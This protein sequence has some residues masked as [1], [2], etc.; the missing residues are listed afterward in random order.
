MIPVI[1]CAHATLATAY[2]HARSSHKEICGVCFGRVWQRADER[3]LVNVDE[4][5]PAPQ[6]ISSYAS[7]SFTHEAW[8]AALDHLEALREKAPEHGWRIVGW[9]H[10]HPGLGIFFS[11]VDENS[12]RTYFPRPW[13]VGLVI[14]PKTKAEGWFGWNS[15]GEIVRLEPEGFVSKDGCDTPDAPATD[16]QPKPED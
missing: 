16:S 10:S 7:V 13:H 2:K 8:A 15:A 6:M 5:W 12:H 4:C 3:Y 9:Y 11:S 14:D 1:E